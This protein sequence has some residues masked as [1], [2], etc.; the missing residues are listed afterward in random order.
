MLL[1]STL[2]SARSLQVRAISL[3]VCSTLHSNVAGGGDN[4]VNIWDW[5]SKKRLS[6]LR[7]F[8]TSISALSF[9]REG[10]QLAIASSYTWDEGDKPHPAD[11][12]FIRTVLDSEVKPKP[13]A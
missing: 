4:F 5:N 10:S 6:Q 1:P 12:I 2:F 11:A 13:K 7:E 8:P 9:N 3:S